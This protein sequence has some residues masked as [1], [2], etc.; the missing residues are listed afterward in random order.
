MTQ[1]L[2]CL[3][4]IMKPSDLQTPLLLIAAAMLVMLPAPPACAAESGPY[5]RADGGVN[6]VTGTHLDIDGFP[7][8]LSLDTGFRVDGAFGYQLNRW[9]AVEFEGG[10]AENSVRSI[11]LQNQTASPQGDSSLRQF[12]LL[13]NIVARYENATDFV[14]YLGVGAGG[15]LSTLRI[16]GNS[17]NEAVLGLQAKAGIIYKIEEQAWL[18][19]GYKLLGTAE[20]HYQIGGVHLQTKDLFNHFIGLSVIWNF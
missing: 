1:V 13:V 15:V 19:I 9:L 6:F 10:M 18:D 5:L 11:S 12:P 20:Q 4:N 17:D 8:T 3:D 7:G 2:S 16:S 14:P